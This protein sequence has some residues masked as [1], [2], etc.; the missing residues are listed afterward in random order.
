MTYSTQAAARIPPDAYEVTRTMARRSCASVDS[1]A[2]LELSFT[3]WDMEAFARDLGDDGPPFRWDEERRTLM[4]AEL[5]AA[6]FHLYGIE[7][8]DMDTSWTPSMRSGGAGEAADFGAFRTK[9]LI[10]ESYDAMAEA[11]RTGVPYQTILDPPPGHGPRHPARRKPERRSTVA[12]SESAGAA[13][14]DGP[15]GASGR[16]DGRSSRA[17]CSDEIERRV[18]LTPYEL[19]VDDSGCR[20]GDVHLGSYRGCRDVGWMTKRGG[21]AITEAGIEAL[22][23]YPTPDELL[24]ELNRLYREIDQRR[25]QAQQNLSDVQQFIATTLRL[26][27]PGTWTAHDD[28]A[29]LA[30]TTAEEVA[31][32]LASGKVRLANAYRVLNADGSIP[33]EGMLNWP[34]RGTDLRSRLAAEGVEF[35]ARGRARKISG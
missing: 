2:V 23:T 3:A 10:L 8:D 22:E 19:S 27:E 12:D 32:F 20:A 26:V 30:G 5:D 17:R 9:E 15:G 28:L 11:M 34:Y 16:R 21:W 31:D 29:D 1:A 25:K 6:Y 14:P 7:R 35:D 33:D 4:R 13:C 24:A 18:Q